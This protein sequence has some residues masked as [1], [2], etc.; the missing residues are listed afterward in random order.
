MDFV[1]FFFIQMVL[2]LG[3]SMLVQPSCAFPRKAEKMCLVNLQRTPVDD[4]C[5]EKVYCE[6]DV[7]FDLLR[8][9]L[10]DLDIGEPKKDFFEGF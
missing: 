4:R 3:T 5:V 2:A 9:E 1:V 6:S 10:T 8:Q 7:F